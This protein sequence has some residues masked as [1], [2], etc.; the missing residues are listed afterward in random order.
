MA[1]LL[2]DFFGGNDQGGLLGLGAPNS[3]VRMGMSVASMPGS[4]GA[5]PERPPSVVGWGD[6]IRA[7]AGGAPYRQNLQTGEWE[8]A[9]RSGYFPVTAPAG[10]ATIFP[11]NL[12]NSGGGGVVGGGGGMQQLGGG[13]GNVSGNNV[14]PPGARFLPTTGARPSFG[15][16][17]I[18]GF[19]RG[20]LLGFGA[21]GARPLG[22]PPRTNFL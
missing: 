14:R 12:P 8:P 5:F 2:D 18:G 7:A 11:W 13:F 17:G 4:R 1:G 20:D 3:M 22:V 10:A 21:F 16:L 9:G 6:E 19:G 15:P